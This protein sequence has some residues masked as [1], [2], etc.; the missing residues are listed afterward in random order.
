ME[1]RSVFPAVAL[2]PAPA[3][4]IDDAAPA[5]LISRPCKLSGTWSKPLP[6]LFI[7]VI[8]MAS[9]T[10]LNIANPIWEAI[11]EPGHFQYVKFVA[12]QHRLPSV[13]E[14]LPSLAVAD[15]ASHCVAQGD[16]Q[17]ELPLY[18]LVEAPF[19][20]PID[21][22]SNVSWVANPH[23]TWAGYPDRDGVALH[24]AT[25]AWPYRGM[26]LGVH[27]MRAVSAVMVIGAL[28]AIYF[29]AAAIG[30]GSGF[31][32][33]A[34]AVAA[35]T[36][37]LLLTSASV[38]NDNAAILTCSLA[39][40]GAVRAVTDPAR[41]WRWLGFAALSTLLALF[42]KGSS[43]FLVP[44][45]FLV[46]LYIA[47]R[48]FQRFDM[49]VPL[50]GIGSMLILGAVLLRTTPYQ[51]RATI[52]NLPWEIAS[53]G[54]DWP[55]NC[56]MFAQPL[57]GAIPN[58]WETWWGSYG[59][60]TFHPPAPFYRP[61]LAVT[62]LAVAGVL[63][64]IWRNVRL[65]LRN[66]LHHRD[67]AALLLLGGA[68][69]LL[70]TIVD[71]R[72]IVSHSSGGTT[73]ARFLFPAIAA[74]A[75]LI[76]AGL[77]ILPR[78]L[79][80]FGFVLLFSSSLSLIGYSA[81]ILPHAFGSDLPVF[82]DLDIARVE[83]QTTID[84]TSGMRVVGWNR[85]LDASGQAGR[86]VHLRLL[87]ET[88]TTPDFDYSAFLHL[89]GPG[90]YVIAGPDHGPGLQIGVLP[91]VWQPGEVIPDDWTLQIPADA[92][93]GEYQVVVGVY[94]YRDLKGIRTNQGQ[95]S[96]SLGQLPLPS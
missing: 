92:P 87:W 70:L 90:G 66:S 47:R 76:A 32:V 78:W 40:L 23:F 55:C 34:T 93:P 15:C 33:L 52:A 63:L 96:V 80:V 12:E 65:G 54:Q 71:V 83:H 85:A 36:P 79:R 84:F 39:L 94:D 46:A 1:I 68:F 37:G 6:L 72:V 81:Y 58:L 38:N 21:L 5:E 4:R 50:A 11:D 51:L 25:E 69:M 35:V 61:F 19:V 48:Y 60:E 77:F 30:W 29:T 2:G 13:S 7:L 8:F 56:T 75:I 64:L 95:D 41:Q 91:H 17:R 59:W 82:G 14:H 43:Y 44:I 73:H 67:S 22:N 49:R 10:F 89:V 26:V 24:L 18:Y 20:L 42:A 9:S 74:G 3:S 31:A 57:W 86:S 16:V 62:L 45:V 53:V 88:W 28:L 27:V